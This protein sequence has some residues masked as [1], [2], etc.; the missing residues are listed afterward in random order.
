MYNSAVIILLGLREKTYADS[1]KIKC[2]KIISLA[3]MFSSISKTE[4]IFTQECSSNKGR[5]AAN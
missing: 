3:D 4:T 5:K 2:F 1:I